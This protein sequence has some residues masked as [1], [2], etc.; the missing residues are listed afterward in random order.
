MSFPLFFKDKKYIIIDSAK[1][2]LVH[3]L[4]TAIPHFM[5]QGQVSYKQNFISFLGDIREI[6]KKQVY[7]RSQLLM[8][9]GTRT[10]LCLFSFQNLCLSY[11][12]T[13]I[14]SITLT[15]I[16]INLWCW[17]FKLRKRYK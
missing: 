8:V 12:Y 6:L 10:S 2:F 7:R 11:L 4:T 1:K 16:C 9:D 13:C 15:F 14:K 17:I 3:K 5:L